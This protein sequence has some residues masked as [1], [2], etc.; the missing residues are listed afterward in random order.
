MSSH[1]KLALVGLLVL[2]GS[3]RVGAQTPE[4]QKITELELQVKKLTAQVEDLKAELKA[5][6]DAEAK[7]RALAEDARAEALRQR[8][9][10]EAERARAE[11]A[12]K[13]AQEQFLKQR[14]VGRKA[15]QE[16]EALRADALAQRQQAE[17]VRQEAEKALKDFQDQLRK[18][19]DAEA[20][21]RQQAEALRDEAR[22]QQDR[23]REA[24]F[25]AR[26]EAEVL[27]ARTR[28]LEARVKELE[29]GRG[30]DRGDDEATKKHMRAVANSFLEGVLARDGRSTSA[31]L[32]KEMRAGF[33]K[34]GTPEFVR[35]AA[36]WADQLAAG[37]RYERATIASESFAPGLDE[38]VFGGQ[39]GGEQRGT[40]SLRVA[41]DRESGRYLIAYVV[42]R[43][44]R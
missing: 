32:T 35:A 1:G 43:P 7:A 40:F 4:V 27:A 39:L 6:Q 24:E 36:E 19:Q 21:A 17:A 30:A 34:E 16:A 9:Q 38:A 11:R 18:Q 14:D 31:V 28:Q 20:K 41:K 10:A 26:Q 44:D 13:D 33:G 29:A 22:A 2:A 37:G 42:T 23:A 5:R 12:L 8:E 25:K 15:Q 3:A